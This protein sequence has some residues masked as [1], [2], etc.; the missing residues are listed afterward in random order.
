MK[1]LVFPVLA[2]FALSSPSFAQ[3]AG[4]PAAETPAATNI[5]VDGE[6]EDPKAEKVICKTERVV[7]SRLNSTKRCQTRQQWEAEQALNRRD[8]ERV[9]SARVK[10]D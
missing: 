10:N 6:K 9:Q 7:G 8:L 4:A 1:I 5:V 2:A 3:E